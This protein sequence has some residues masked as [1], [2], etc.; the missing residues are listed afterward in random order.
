MRHIVPV[1][2]L[3]LLTISAKAQQTNISEN[4][5]LNT[6]EK[7]LQTEGKLIIGGY[8]EVHYHQ[9]FSSDKSYNGSLDVHRMVMLLGYNFSSKTQFISEIEYE[10]V[11]EVYIE[12]AFLQ[13][14]INN[15]LNIRAGLVLIPM[16]IV[17][18]YHEPTSFNGVERPQVD[19]RISPTTW[20][21]IGAGVSGNVLAATLKYQVYLVNG[22]S[23]YNGTA[24][25]SG[26]N[27]FRNGR[28]KGA[29]S[30][31]STPNFTFKTEYYG[32]RGL[33]LGLSGYFGMTE[34]SLYN[35]IDKNNQSL[36]AKADSSVVG[37]NMFGIDG[38]YT[39][40]GLQVRGQ[41]YHANISN[42][43]QYNK[44]T[45][46]NGKQNDLG[47]KMQGYYLEAGYNVFKHLKKT[48]D[49]C[50]PFARI[51]SY[52]THLATMNGLSQNKSY[53]NKIITTGIT[54]KLGKG[55]VVKTDLQFVKSE[56]AK[57]YSKQ[58]S[59]GFGVMF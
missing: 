9:P 55:A 18:E 37:L 14:K 27:G 56:A 50:I 24:N 13:H 25:L 15:Y 42:T 5:Y 59:A 23:S 17:N 54:Y 51:E 12:Q 44:F 38:R 41:Y 4:T 29:E 22:F 8:G 40:G 30:F 57:D 20:R 19:S 16:G 28:Q 39:L 49:E 52:D 26:K 43:A 31:I 35:G 21:E 48:R 1:I 32:F 53:H 7:L 11:K 46:M 3:L 2:F 34:S 10:H 45:T 36:Q 47:S 58:F 33:N 6:A